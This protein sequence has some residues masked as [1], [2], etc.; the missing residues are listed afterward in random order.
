MPISM[1]TSKGQT[2][3]PK[4][5][6]D[7]LRLK[8]KDKL[9]YVIEGNTVVVRPMHG[10][11]VGLRG[12]FKDAVKRPIRFRKLRED[13]RRAVGKRVLRDLQ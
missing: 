6:R 9:L 11:I 8:P 1:V 5:V 3:I 13:T 12:V 7:A 10:T 4:S 2:T